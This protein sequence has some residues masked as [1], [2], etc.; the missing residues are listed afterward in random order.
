MAGTDATTLGSLEGWPHVLQSIGDILRTPVGSRVMRR[1]YGSRLPDLIGRPM[2]G[3]T[4]AQVYAASALAIAVWEPRFRLT[5]V[6]VAR[7][8]GTG[9]L[10]IDIRGEYEGNVVNG[11]V[12]ME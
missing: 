5:G 11:R 3:E 10:A 8:E 12:P 7:S 4:V 6:Q 2:T 1:E 9:H